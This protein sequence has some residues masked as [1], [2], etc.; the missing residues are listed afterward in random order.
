MGNN[1][2]NCAGSLFNAIGNLDDW[3]NPASRRGYMREARCFSSQIEWYTNPFTG[4]A[5]SRIC[6]F[7][8]GFPVFGIYRKTPVTV[9]R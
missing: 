4:E 6:E 5:V 1:L 8:I 2:N 3:W 7:D 9:R